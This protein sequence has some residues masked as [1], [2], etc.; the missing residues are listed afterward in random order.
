LYESIKIE[1]PS[2]TTSLTEK[3]KAAIKF[4]SSDW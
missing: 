1:F 2:T 3:L 4:Y